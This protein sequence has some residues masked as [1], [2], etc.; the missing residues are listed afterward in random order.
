M[1]APTS[2]SVST[3][4]PIA[5]AWPFAVSLNASHPPSASA[6]FKVTPPT[7]TARSLRGKLNL[8]TSPGCMAPFRPSACSTGAQ[9]AVL[10]CALTGELAIATASATSTTAVFVIV[11]NLRPLVCIPGSHNIEG[12]SI[13]LRPSA[14]PPAA[15]CV[16]GVEPSPAGEHGVA[17]KAC[18]PDETEQSCNAACLGIE[19]VGGLARQHLYICVVVER[20][21]HGSFRLAGMLGEKPRSD[22]KLLSFSG[23]HHG[24]RLFRTGHAPAMRRGK[25]QHLLDRRRIARVAKDS[26]IAL[27][28][29]GDLRLAGT[30][31]KID[32]HEHTRR[33]RSRDRAV[34]RTSGIRRAADH[35]RAVHLQQF[36]QVMGDLAQ[37]VIARRATLVL[38]GVRR[39]LSASSAMEMFT[40][41][42]S[43]VIRMP[44]VTMRVQPLE[45]LQLATVIAVQHRSEE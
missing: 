37:H 13:S 17:L 14:H 45:P 38:G 27:R 9:F 7:V 41:R 40:R 12:R 36:L 21:F 1:T 31:R 30:Q 5:M 11:G 44:A 34:E 35:H 16:G 29:G 23:R 22:K 19:H 3:R 39:R 10:D 24:E 8:M 33:E 32:A 42:V 2:S 25:I 18:R 43:H 15:A 26:R 20:E 6:G 28:S 4:S